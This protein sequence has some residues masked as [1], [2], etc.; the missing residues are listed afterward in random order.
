MLTPAIGERKFFDTAL[1][2]CGVFGCPRLLFSSIS[3]LLNKLGSLENDPLVA[4]TARYS[5]AVEK[6]QQRNSVFARNT[7]Q[8]LKLRHV[9]QPLGFVLRSEVPQQSA[10]AIDGANVQKQIRL[11]AHQSPA[12]KQHLQNFPRMG[13]LSRRNPGA[14]ESLVKS[15][16]F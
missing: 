7:R 12:I 9:N 11:G 6:F 2:I 13:T 5:F 14:R 16:R 15:W 1:L 3:W 4:G 10:Q 8:G